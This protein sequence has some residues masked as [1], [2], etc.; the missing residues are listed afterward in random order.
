WTEF[1]FITRVVPPTGNPCLVPP[2]GFPCL[3][4]PTVFPSPRELSNQSR[5]F[6]CFCFFDIFW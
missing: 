6:F 1:V 4:P 3:V 2:T 5:F